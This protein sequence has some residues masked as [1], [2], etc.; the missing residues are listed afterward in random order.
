MRKI[1]YMPDHCYMYN[2]RYYQI[3]DSDTIA[4]KEQFVSDFIAGI[5][6]GQVSLYDYNNLFRTV[7]L[8]DTPECYKEDIR[9]ILSLIQL[10][11]IVP[12]KPLFTSKATI[13]K[14][15]FKG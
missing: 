1:V 15:R 11:N 3:W 13:L 5:E 6:S 8:T 14:S 9:Y 2:G 7:D 10:S 12:K 4:R